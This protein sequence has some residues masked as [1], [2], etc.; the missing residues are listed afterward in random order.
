[1]FESVVGHSA[2]KKYLQTM[3]LSGKIPHTMIFHGL[4]GIGKGTLAKEFGKAAGIAASDIWEYAPAGKSALH[5]IDTLR[6]C[7]EEASSRPYESSRKLIIIHDADRML[8]ASSNA[9][10]KTLE[11]PLDTTHIIL[12]TDSIE[13]LIET[14]R[15]RAV[16]ILFSALEEQEVESLLPSEWNVQEKQQAAKLSQGSVASALNAKEL[17]QLQDLVVSLPQ[18]AF[19]HDFQRLDSSLQKL[20]ETLDEQSFHMVDLVFTL[21]LY[22]FRDQEYLKC[23]VAVGL[24]YPGIERIDGIP[25]LQVVEKAMQKALELHRL[26]TKMKTALEGFFYSVLRET[27]KGFVTR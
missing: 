26:H 15:S 16:H 13:S 17:L 22:W 2:P 19:S 6:A 21:L 1:M 3:L 24:F 18:A 7:I 14:V 12:T 27:N 8:K 4:D 23:G 11:E 9:L 5:T 10:L 20:S 25:P